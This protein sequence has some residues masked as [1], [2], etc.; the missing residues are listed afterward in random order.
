MLIGLTGGIGAG[1]SVVARILRLK[2]Y[3]VY[4]CDIRARELMAQSEHILSSLL[5]RFGEDCITDAGLPDRIYLAKMVFGNDD[6]RRWLNALVHE[7]VRRDLRR[8]VKGKDVSF[9]ESAILRSS[10]LD[11]ICG[12]IW[13]VTAPEDVR[14]ARAMA[15]DGAEEEKIRL[16]IRAQHGEFEFDNQ[17]LSEIVN[18][19]SLSLLNQI[20]KELENIKI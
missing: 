15:R 13:V 8:W 11:R 6:H 12:R 17:F 9:V 3:P 5:E 1:K 10:H 2:G 19:G 18:D 16:R 7:E 20:D 4:D 14:I